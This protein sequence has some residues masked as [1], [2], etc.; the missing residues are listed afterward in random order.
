MRLLIRLGAL[1]LV[2]GGSV[3][4]VRL[5]AISAD[6]VP[7][8]PSSPS[9]T[10]EP[11]SATGA[12][13]QSTQPSDVVNFNVRGSLEDLCRGLTPEQCAEAIRA[14]QPPQIPPPSPLIVPR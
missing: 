7:V 13:S 4:A 9:T 8:S 11:M 10:V 14:Q 3:A 5:A 6:P 12:T 1:A 2:A